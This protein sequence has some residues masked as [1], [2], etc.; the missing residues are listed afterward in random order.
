MQEVMTEEA[1]ILFV[2]EPSVDKY[3]FFSGVHQEASHRPTAEVVVIRR[4][5]LIPYCFRNYPKHSAAIK[6]QMAC[7]NRNDFHINTR[8]A[9]WW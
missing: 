9:S 2:A 3:D 4:D 7:F 6:F 1:L 5:H 8:F